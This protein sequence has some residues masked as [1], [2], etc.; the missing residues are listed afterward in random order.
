M[1]ESPAVRIVDPMDRRKELQ[2]YIDDTRDNQRRFNGVLTALIAATLLVLIWNSAAGVLALLIVGIVA[3]GGHWVLY[4]HLESHRTQ[5]AELER[6]RRPPEGPQSGGHRRWDR[7][8]Q[9]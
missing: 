4:A 2:R 6:M 7:A 1:P 3:I 9:I 8:P 5:L